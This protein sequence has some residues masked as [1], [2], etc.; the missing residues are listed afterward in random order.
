MRTLIEQQ[1]IDMTRGVPFM[2]ARSFGRYWQ[3]DK[4]RAAVIAELDAGDTEAT[5]WT[6]AAQIVEYRRVMALLAGAIELARVGAP[7]AVMA[8][9]S[10]H[11]GRRQRTP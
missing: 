11:V 9:R 4:R 3:V 10:P 8:S 6:M 2:A 7:F 1:C 5:L